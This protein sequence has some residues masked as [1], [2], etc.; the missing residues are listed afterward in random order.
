MAS[1]LEKLNELDRNYFNTLLPS[2]DGKYIKRDTIIKIMLSKT[3]YDKALKVSVDA[4]AIVYHNESFLMKSK[5]YNNLNAHSLQIIKKH[6]AKELILEH[7][8]KILLNINLY[9][10]EK[11][12]KLI[13]FFEKHSDWNVDWIT[14]WEL[15]KSFMNDTD[16]MIQIESKEISDN[17]IMIFLT[18]FE[19]KMNKTF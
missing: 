19:K 8:D 13:N 2:I 14:K 16:F 9:N 17:E 12:D 4:G 1:F 7:E 10:L 11:I 5:G 3:I 15:K 18:E 6:F